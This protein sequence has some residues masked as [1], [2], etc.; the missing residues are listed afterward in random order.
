MN[1]YFKCGIAIQWK[2]ISQ[3]KGKV[4]TYDTAWMNREK[5]ILSEKSNSEKMTY[6]C[7]LL[8]IRNF[9]IGKS[10]E[11]EGKLLIMRM[12]FLLEE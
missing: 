6:H 10:I 4:L 3:Q 7:M 5:N 12:K 1:G 2:S 11:I 8:F 9:Q